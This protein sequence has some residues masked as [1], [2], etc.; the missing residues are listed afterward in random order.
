M[1]VRTLVIHLC[2]V[3]V[4]SFRSM[5]NAPA[6]EESLAGL[7]IFRQGSGKNLDGHGALETRV[8]RAIHLAHAARSQRREDLIGP[9]LVPSG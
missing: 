7:R 6:K 5:F 4:L 2:G 3:S 8:A 9:E 1:S